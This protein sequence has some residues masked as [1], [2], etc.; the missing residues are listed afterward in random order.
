MSITDAQYAAW[1][2]DQAAIRCILVEVDIGLKSG[3]SVTRYLSNKVYVTSPTDTPSN[4][5]YMA[6]ITGGIRF[7]RKISLDGSVSLSFGDIE[8]T[9]M[10]GLLDSWIDDYFANRP[11]RI[12]LG[13]VTW[14]RADF[15]RVFTGRTLGIDTRKRETINIKLSDNLQRLNQPVTTNVLGGLT[16][17]N[18]TLL[19]VVF[20]EVFNMTPICTNA[21]TN[22]Y[23]VHDGAHEAIIEVRDNGV[24]VGITSFPNTGKFV[25][26]SQPYGTVTASVQGGLIPATFY[27]SKDDLTTG[28][29]RTNLVAGTLDPYTGPYL[30]HA[31]AKNNPIVPTTT[32]G[33]HNVLMVASGMP[34][35]S[36]VTYSCFVK[37]GTAKKVAFDL[38][39]TST[40]ANLLTLSFD[41]DTHVATATKTGAAVV[42]SSGAV[43]CINGWWRIWVTG[44][45]DSTST[46]ATVRLQVSDAVGSMTYAGDGTTVYAYASGVQVEDGVFPTGFWTEGVPTRFRKTLAELVRNLVMNYGLE[47]QR[48][49]ISEINIPNFVR[50]EAMYRQ[51]VGIPIMDRQNVLDIC[52]QLA[53]SVGARVILDA[54]GLLALVKVHLP[55]VDPGALPINSSD[56]IDRSL[57]I[58]YLA[59]VVAAVKLGYCKNWTV[60]DSGLAAGLEQTSVPLFTD[61]WLT[62]TMQDSEV[63]ANYNLFIDPVQQDT[64]LLKEAD[65]DFE[66]TRRLGMYSVQRKV[67]KFVG[68][69]H[70]INQD[71]GAN[72]TITHPR[73]GLSGGVTGQIISIDVDFTSP[74]ITFE[75]IL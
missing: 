3:G 19:P 70:L 52:N 24:P 58:S 28:W 35:G 43:D 23:Q 42:T 66:A 8:L 15:R 68:F 51:P 30:G 7:S 50:F 39:S 62:A 47:S 25:L 55:V 34:G 69:Y 31:G 1:L 72:V 2:E 63:S 5:S 6:R 44:V 29:T 21:S 40:P 11:F 74:Q 22:E 36:T 49:L 45:I 37:K 16:A 59:P 18:E 71:L 67:M 14:G 56:F 73:F 57:E 61:E 48:F 75:V 4:L 65:A 13:D 54:N 38:F 9:N 26:N 64:L 27:L 46:S 53:D 12:Y 33:L 32:N 10:D 60:Q 17:V 20:G 41:F